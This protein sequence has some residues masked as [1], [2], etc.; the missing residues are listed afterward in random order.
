MKDVINTSLVRL[1]LPMMA[2]AIGVMVAATYPEL[3]T[4]FCEAR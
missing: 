1:I 3:F 4:A 2:G